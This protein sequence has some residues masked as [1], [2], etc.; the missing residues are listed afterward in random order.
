VGPVRSKHLA[1]IGAA[2]VALSACLPI[3][4]GK[5]TD[6]LEAISAIK[7]FYYHLDVERYS[8]ESLDGVVSDDF[9]IFE[10][11]QAM[12]R[13]QF[14]EYL[15]HTD[16]SADPLSLTRWNQ[17]DFQ[18]SADKNSIHVT[19]HNSGR[20]EHGSSLVVE[21]EWLESALFIRTSKGLKLKFLNVNLV[22]K[23]INREL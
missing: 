18:T 12:N 4:T 19:Y 16:D 3:L 13:D 23:A 7:N 1:L 15:S 5:P 6:H 2:C 9:L 20:F 14:H 8:P 10:S 22:S 21:I 11:G 17:S